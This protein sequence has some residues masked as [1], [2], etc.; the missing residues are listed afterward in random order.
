M[1]TGFGDSQASFNVFMANRPVHPIAD[2]EEA[3]GIIP[4]KSDDIYQIGQACGNGWR[5]V[6]NVY[7]KLLYAL[8]NK[9]WV[10]KQEH[11]SWQDY[12]DSRL[13]QSGS[14]TALYFR[15]PN[16]DE[17]HNC[18]VNIAMGKTF[19]N[20]VRFS[21]SLVWLDDEFA[22]IPSLIV[23]PYFDYRQLSNAKI[24]RL[25]SLINKAM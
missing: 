20:G 1:V 12:R 3:T 2:T 23:C 15:A 10:D 11:K 16:R 13:L 18:D 24:I 9:N 17:L 7:A 25:V 22:Q 14:K 21:D 19:A 6:F 8:D 5:K 4:L